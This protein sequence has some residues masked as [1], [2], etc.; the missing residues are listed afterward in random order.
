[1]TVYDLEQSVATEQYPGLA[2]SQDDEIAYLKERGRYPLYK[3]S[4]A[5][6]SSMVVKTGGCTLYTISG[7][8]NASATVYIHAFDATTVPGSSGVPLFPPIQVPSTSPNF[9]LT[10]GS[11]GARLTTG[12]VVGCSSAQSTFTAV[13]N[14]WFFVTY[15]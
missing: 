2:G 6:V 3:G 11:P 8:S 12:L 4:F 7:V 15:V 13:A 1:M 10:F 5:F 9:S 14:A